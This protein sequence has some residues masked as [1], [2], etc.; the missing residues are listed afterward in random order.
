MT[1]MLPANVNAGWIKEVKSRRKTFS[2]IPP[3]GRALDEGLDKAIGKALKEG[4]H[5]STKNYKGFEH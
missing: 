2:I 3:L 1:V 5:L 4:P